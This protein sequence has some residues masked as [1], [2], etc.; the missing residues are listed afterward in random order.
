MFVVLL[1]YA[2]EKLVFAGVDGFDDVFVVAREVE[3]AFAL[4][5]RTQLRQDVLSSLSRR[6]RSAYVSK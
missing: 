2:P 5:G 3:E 4:A 6:V 1:E